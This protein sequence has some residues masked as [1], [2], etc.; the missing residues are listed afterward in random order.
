MKSFKLK[1]E[2][3]RMKFLIFSAILFSIWLSQIVL[4]Q[5][6]DTLW[7]RTFGDSLFSV[8]NSVQ[9]TTDGGYI[10]TGGVL[11]FNAIAKNDLSGRVW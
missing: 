5:A 9:Q 3:Y 2:S 6:P 7:T 4:S 1:K 10:I 8:G 11:S